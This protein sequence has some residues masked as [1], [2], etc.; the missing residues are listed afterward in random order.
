MGKIKPEDI[1]IEKIEKGEFSIILPEFYE[2]K[3]VIEDDGFWHSRDSV[4]NH[5]IGVLK[6]LGSFLK[7]ANRK[8]LNYLSQ[9]ITDH[10]RKDL[11]FLAALF[12][13]IA[14]DETIIKKDGKTSCPGHEEKGYQKVKSILDRIDLSEKEKNFV[15]QIIKNHGVLHIMVYPGN[16]NLEEEYRVFR[17]DFSEIFLE[18]II[19]SLIDN[20]GNQLQ[21][22]YPDE[23][24]FRINFYQKAL[25]DY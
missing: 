11:L 16:N 15:S 12:H 7:G 1:T 18:I 20:L 25:A 14:K 13:D 10:S 4:F 9:E 2:L 5:T 3:K 23:F 19:F 22:N 8:I 21:K 24:D 6:G 17:S